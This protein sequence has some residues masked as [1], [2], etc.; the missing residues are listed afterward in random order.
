M[1]RSR[2]LRPKP[3]KDFD[4]SDRFECPSGHANNHEQQRTDKHLKPLSV[5]ELRD[6]ESA[7]L[8]VTDDWPKHV[9]ITAAEIDAIE[10]FLR[11]VIDALLK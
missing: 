8:T 4:G 2:T 6:Q 9:P 5:D 7:N 3:V 11:E 1:S 10:A